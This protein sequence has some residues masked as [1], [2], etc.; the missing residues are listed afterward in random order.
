MRTQ[1]GSRVEAFQQREAMTPARPGRTL[2]TS[3]LVLALAAPAV[4]GADDEIEEVLVSA[5]R[6]GVV[7]QR[8][9]VLDSGDLE[10]VGFHP[11]DLLPLLPGFA[12][13][14][15]GARG[16]LSQARVRGAEANHLLVM[17]DGVR[18]NDPA[19][20]SEFDFGALDATAINRVEYL[21]GPQS[22]VW[23]SD[24]VAGVLHLDTM[25]RVDERRVRIGYGSHETT[26]VD[27][28][29]A[30]AREDGHAQ[31]ALGH[32]ASDGTNAAW[33]GTEDDGFSTTTAHFGWG[34]ES[35][36]WDVSFAARATDAEAAYDPT[37]A[38]LYIPMDG[39]R[40][41]ETRSGLVRATARYVGADRFVPWLTIASTRTDR[42]QAAD[43]VIQTS[44]TGRRDAAT[45]SA[46]LLRGR[47]RLN[48]TGEHAVE[49]F[50][51][52]GE[53]SLFGDP[54]QDQRI[55]TSSLAAEYQAGLAGVSV[56]VS[57]R[58]DANSA[59]RNSVS[60]RLGATTGTSPRLFASVGRGVKNPTFVE[61]FGYAPNAF[62][63]NPALEP[64]T[65]FGAELG[66]AHSWG[67]A[68]LTFL[69][70]D[71]SLDDEIDGF[72]FDTTRGGFTA[73]NVTGASDRRGAELTLDATWHGARWRA[74]Y[75]YVDS[76]SDGS[77]EIRRPR[78]LGSIAVR[79]SFSIF[80]PQVSMG[81]AL[82]QYGDSLDRDFSTYPATPVTL[83]GFRLL[84]GDLK[85]Q[86]SPR[87]AI[88]LLVENALDE[89]HATVYGYRSPGM[90]AMARAIIE[91]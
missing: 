44:T 6:I 1:T 10:T 59:F 43:G 54:N 52:A 78:H 79:R 55:T 67:D 32:T 29:F 23:G 28:T 61:R 8:V 63:G 5:S 4:H 19:A 14:S 91:I 12:L 30:R 86:P 9:V 39:D 56:S 46:N 85:I 27:A 47:Q 90:S 64:E 38:P 45:L 37:P 26:S 74:A 51:Q 50:E 84:R 68:T 49:R 24:A 69:V 21:A 3:I 83:D 88:Q 71:A 15:S 16:A 73:R 31:F 25:P 70:F 36:A 18:V 57:A 60:Y 2:G 81:A 53:A 89:D 40:V 82:T 76:T 77:R 20:G 33:H 48:I 22:A 41:G 62:I 87:V 35:T 75:A 13:A 72:V 66:V 11:N 80:P 17:I 58:T 42:R 7:D 34:R 65:S